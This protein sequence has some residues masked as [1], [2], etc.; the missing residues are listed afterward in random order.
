MNMQIILNKDRDFL[1]LYSEESALHITDY[2]ALNKKIV[3]DNSSIKL[4]EKNPEE[5]STLADLK[6]AAEKLINTATTIF[7]RYPP[8]NITPSYFYMNNSETKLLVEQLVMD[9]LFDN[10]IHHSESITQHAYARHIGEILGT[11]TPS[12]IDSIRTNISNY[13]GMHFQRLSSDQ[14]KYEVSLLGANSDEHAAY[15]NPVIKNNSSQVKTLAV[16]DFFYFN[17]KVPILTKQYQRNFTRKN[18]NYSYKSIISDFIE[19]DTFVNRLL[20]NKRANYITYECLMKYYF[21][22][23]Y[24]RIDF[25]IQLAE[26]ILNN[27]LEETTALLFLKW[28]TPRVLQIFESETDK[29]I[30][31]RDKI[32]FYRPLSKIEH[33]LLKKCSKDKNTIKAVYRQLQKCKIIRAKAYELFQYHYKFHAIPLYS[34]LKTYAYNPIYS[35]IND[36]ILNSYNLNSFRE[37]SI[38]LNKIRNLS[39]GT[40]EKDMKKIIV[41]IIKCNHI[42]FPPIPNID[43]IQ[44]MNIIM[45]NF[46]YDCEVIPPNHIPQQTMDGQILTEKNRD[47]PIRTEV[48]KLDRSLD[49]LNKH[50]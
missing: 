5:I 31:F 29:Q 49:I 19:Y 6:K 37:N 28:F 34:S 13:M 10:Y 33:L 40:I 14:S 45:Q 38:F 27:D 7:T 17:S 26:C 44:H 12:D 46:L 11:S 48:L 1:D 50:H 21:L 32:N 3:I 36:F 39:D 16:W 22:N 47:Y 23:S 35:E 43:D 41:E 30:C 18:R 9:I 8:D 24:K 15:F 4:I 2:Q 20:T 42:L 25:I